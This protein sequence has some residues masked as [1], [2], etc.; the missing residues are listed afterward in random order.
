M[1][2]AQ[3]EKAARLQDAVINSPVEELSKVCDELGEVEMAAPA[4]GLACR[5]RGLD[6]VKALVEKGVTFDFPST[7]R[8]RQNTAVISDRSMRTTARITRCIC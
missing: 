1:E 2:L 7:R 5:F 8:L 3:E 4:L 6:A